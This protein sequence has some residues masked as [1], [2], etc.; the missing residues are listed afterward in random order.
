M[1]DNIARRRIGSGKVQGILGFVLLIAGALV[2]A[3]VAYEGLPELAFVGQL[4]ISLGLVL[5]L[6]G[7]VVEALSRLEERLMDIERRTG[8]DPKP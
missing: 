5:L 8:G 7:F 3:T 6:V 1:A 2:A 4:L